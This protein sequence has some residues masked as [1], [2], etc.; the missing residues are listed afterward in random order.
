[1]QANTSPA[2]RPR[3]PWTRWL[4][5]LL[6]AWLAAAAAAA[7]AS[8]TPLPTYRVVQLSTVPDTYYG[9]VNAKGQVAFTEYDNGAYRARFYDGHRIRD[10]GTLGGPSAYTAAVNDLGQVAGTSDVTRDGSISHAFRW[11]AATGMVDLTPA[12]RQRSIAADINKR[13]HVA[14]TLLGTDISV[15]TQG[16]L[17]RPQTGA[18]SIGVLDAYSWATAMNDADAIAGYGG[19]DSPYGVLGFLWT[20]A[21]G[22]RNVDTLPAEFTLAADVNNLG[23]VVGATPF[24]NEPFPAYVHAF[25]WTPQAGPTDLGT[26]SANESSATAVNDHDMVVGRVRDFH[27]FDHGFVWTRD[28]GLLEFAPGHPEIGTFVGGLN[29]LGQVVGGYDDW[30]FL[31]TRD[32]GLV[33]L[34]TRLVG[35]PP[36]LR[37]TGGYAI[38]DGGQIVAHANTGLVLLVPAGAAAQAPAVGPIEPSGTPRANSVLSFVAAVTD[39]DPTAI[40]KAAWDWGDGGTAAAAVSEKQGAG[41]A[42]GQHAFRAPGIYTVKLTVTDSGGRSTTVGTKVVVAAAGAC[43]AGAG[44][45]TS[46]PGAATFAFL[47]YAGQGS[48]EFSTAGLSLRN[49]HIDTQAVRDGKVEYRGSGA[50]NGTAGYRFLLT[51][52]P[53]GQPGSGKATVRMRIWHAAPETHA[54]VVD[55]DNLSDPN[56][57]GG[58][59]SVVREGTVTIQ[60]D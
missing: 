52:T 31:W 39:A 50:V 18:R 33:D 5:A 17:W 45:F 47:A 29:N 59:G 21:G 56:A 48:V 43:T 35:A 12:V 24:P 11:S 32:H 14:G 2:R 16:F 6:A 40:H 4:P 28:M 44:R 34:N 23:H 10:L 3:I 1:M 55:Y 20:P 13:G 8:S 27:I 36:G 38:S 19:A 37:L 42:S 41:S 25:L 22:I 58:A 7:P 60:S 26:G 30:A 51:A 57:T 46:A 53:G 9:A 49:A 15:P 54:D